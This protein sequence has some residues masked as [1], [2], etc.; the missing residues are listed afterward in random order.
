MAENTGEM[1]SNGGMSHHLMEIDM[2]VIAKPVY[3]KNSDSNIAPKQ[4]S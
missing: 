4:S 3:N 1:D 2:I